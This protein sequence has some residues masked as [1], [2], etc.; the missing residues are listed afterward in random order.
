MKDIFDVLTIGRIGVDIYP[1]GPGSL[2]DV[3]VFEKYLGGSPTNVAVAAAR[4]GERSAVISRTGPDPFGKFVHVALQ[5]YGVDDRYVT[6]VE[7]FQ[8][9]VTFCEILTPDSFPLYF[10]REPKAPD[11]EIYSEELDREAIVAARLF[12]ATVSGLSVEPSRSSTLEALA[13]RAR[14]HPTVLDLDWRPTFWKSPDDARAL[15]REALGLVTVAIG[16]LSEVEMAVG[17][18]DPDVGADRLLDL[19]LELVIVKMGP[20]GVLG[21]TRD[22]RVE[23]A[24]MPIDVVNGLGAGDGFGGAF[25]HALLAGWSLERILRFANAAG[26]IVASRLACSEAMPTIVEIDE[27]LKGKTNA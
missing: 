3:K 4:L 24:P 9:P 8:T 22:E 18:S 2:V 13:V 5:G 20:D 10:Y 19:G 27:L 6:D 23:V 14:R 21:K 16:N 7:G 11:L 12:W 15:T 25:C 26:A 1:T 17:T